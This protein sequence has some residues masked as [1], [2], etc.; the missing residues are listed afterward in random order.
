MICDFNVGF[1]NLEKCQLI[2]DKLIIFVLRLRRFL[3][4][5]FINLFRSWSILDRYMD[6]FNKV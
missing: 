6:K 2:F 3:E 5:R 1:E 4:S